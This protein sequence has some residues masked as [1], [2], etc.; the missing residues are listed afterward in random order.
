ML[1]WSGLNL[2]LV[3][4]F[5]PFPKALVSLLMQNVLS[6]CVWVWAASKA[7]VQCFVF[8]ILDSNVL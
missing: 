3:F 2:F 6:A 8:K 7:L 4:L 5:L 1:F